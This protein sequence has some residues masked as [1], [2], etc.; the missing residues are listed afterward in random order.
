MIE[1]TVQST[2]SYALTTG[3]HQP[4]YTSYEEPGATDMV[5]LSTGDFSFNLPLLEVPGPEGGF[6]VPLTYNAGIGPDQEA[7]WVGLGWTLNVGAFTRSV[8]QYPDDA[9]GEVQSITRKDLVGVRGWTSSALG[10]GQIGWNTAQ[11]HYGTLSLLSIINVSYDN[12]GTT[13][14]VAGLNVGPSGVSI[15]GAQFMMAAF[16]I[17]SMG[18]G[19]VGEYVVQAGISVGVG[20]ALSFT[21]SN[22]TPNSPTDGY[23]EYSK[24]TSS[25]FLGI[26]EDYWIWLD[27]T[28][29]EEMLGV[30][31]F[32]KA[33]K[34]PHVATSFHSLATVNFSYTVNGSSNQT[35]LEY[36]KTGNSQGTASDINYYIPTGVSYRDATSPVVLGTDNYSVKAPGISGSIKPYRL[37]VGSVSMPRQMG[38]Y[39]NRL[40]L[41]PAQPY[42]VPF[43]YEGSNTNSHFYHVGSATAVIS[44]TFYYGLA[45]SVGNADPAINSTLSYSLNDVIF[46]NRIRPDLISNYKIPMANHTEWL[47]NDEI[48]SNTQTYFSSGFMNYFS[49]TDRSQFRQTFTFGPPKYVY[50][51][52]SDFTNGRINIQSQELTYFSVDQA[53]T[54]QVTAYESGYDFA[55]GTGNK[56]TFTINTT[57][58]NVSNGGTSGPW[59]VD[60]VITGYVYSSIVNKYCELQVNSGG[61]KRPNSIG[62]YSITGINGITY[63][64]ALPSYEYS[65]YTKIQDPQSPTTKYSEITRNEPFASTWLLTGITGPDFV[66]RGGA[67]NAPNGMIDVNDWGYW[68]KFN[69][70]KYS[71]D[72]QWSIPF[73]GS[74]PD[75]INSSLTS[76]SGHRQMYY[77]NS[78]ET[79]THVA[80]FL[81]ESRSDNRGTNVG[82]S[83]AGLSLRLSEID[84]ITRETYQ[85]LSLPDAGLINIAKLW[86]TTDFFSSSGSYQGQGTFII[87]NALKRV[88][89]THT[90]DLC[91]NTTNSV[92]TGQGKLTLTR[93]SM[94]GRNENKIVPDYKFEYG[95]NPG[96]DA[97][98][99]DGWGMYPTILATCAV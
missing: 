66:D 76:T 61:P 35:A 4:E 13:V 92:A 15:D 54:I 50:S 36:N 97:N 34:I 73:S 48:I 74:V 43:I 98:K 90:Y 18:A 89:F 25:G 32:D 51:S 87:Q 26:W 46:Q 77:L 2:I 53:V 10:L 67:S 29:Y 82:A 93:V 7:S 59:Y 16:S 17:A 57:V 58:S 65:N 56:N 47:T 39:H 99:W 41:V 94:L 20:A 27:Q 22:Q 28:R 31:N 19:T 81:K 37:E 69:Y 84:L 72:F 83:F 30:L 24:R 1:S 80:L 21:A 68:V 45:K 3:P 64:F 9:S 63:H 49:G 70:G 55:T 85:Q 23:W 79:R 8:V 44:P 40:A 60:V 6:S 86:M 42:K 75:A 78:I 5:N 96:Y 95:N 52:S 11:G 91:P 14:G 71:D 88:K 33:Q 62:G 38:Q 12:Q